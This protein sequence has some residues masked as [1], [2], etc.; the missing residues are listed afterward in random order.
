M[1]KKKSSG[2][3]GL[4]KEIIYFIFVCGLIV[5]VFKIT[6]ISDGDSGYKYFKNKSDQTKNCYLGKGCVLDLGAILSG[7]STEKPFNSKNKTSNSSTTN[8]ETNNDNPIT[9][10]SSDSEA[11]NGIPS[12]SLSNSTALKELYLLKNQKKLNMI[13]KNGIIGFLL[14]PINVGTLVKKV[15]QIKL[16]QVA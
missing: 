1:S 8:N 9:S 15:Y 14:D 2:P 10:N 16:N 7:N 12:T 3:V 4:I 6:G 13:E 11:I 5:G